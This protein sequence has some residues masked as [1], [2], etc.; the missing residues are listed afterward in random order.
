M[1]TYIVYH[2]NCTDGFG[3]AYSAWKRFG[4]SVEYVPMSAGGKT[5]TFEPRSTIFFLDVAPDTREGLLDLM[6]DNEV[7]IIDHHEKN[8]H[9]FVGIKNCTFDM[10]HSGCY[11]AWKYFNP[12][13][14]VPKFIEYIEKKDLFKYTPI[15]A[16]IIDPIYCIPFDF[17]TWEACLEK[18]FDAKVF[19]E[20]GIAIGR[21]KEFQMML[22]MN[23]LHTLKIAGYYVPAINT[24]ENVSELANRLC[25]MFPEAPFAVCY[26]VSSEGQYSFSLRSTGFNVNHLAMK[27][28]GGGHPK[29]SGFRIPVNVL[30]FERKDV[31]NPGV[32]DRFYNWF[33][34]KYF[35][36]THGGVCICEE[37]RYVVKQ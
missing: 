34:N 28:G 4:D 12:N 33:Y 1:K 15:E 31:E 37:N 11:L 22:A 36:P 14:E 27:F 5:P 23:G 20:Q 6:K 24:K 3:A 35:R 19:T 25:T 8:M 17:L 16:L 7:Y 30:D 21:N 10:S 18:G 2:S 26:S 32:L 9:E 13:I 29:A